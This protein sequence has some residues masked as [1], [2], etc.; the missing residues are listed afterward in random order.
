MNSDPERIRAAPQDFMATFPE[1]GIQ[2]A[3][4]D[5]VAHFVIETMR[6]ETPAPIEVAVLGPLSVAVR[7]RGRGVN[8]APEPGREEVSHVVQAFSNLYPVPCPSREVEG[9][10]RD[11]VWKD[12]ASLG[13]VVANA[14]TA[15]LEVLSQRSSERWCQEFERGLPRGGPYRVPSF[16]IGTEIRAQFLAEIRG[17]A[18]ALDPDRVWARLGELE[19]SLP[20]L[21]F[22][23]M[24]ALVPA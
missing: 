24:R 12:R 4:E 7:D 6:S 23:E 18:M 9:V 3:F 11:W 19:G 14:C 15:R 21:R 10:L 17:Q 1:T 20:G 22:S 8:F 16:E 13:P 5:L 2:A